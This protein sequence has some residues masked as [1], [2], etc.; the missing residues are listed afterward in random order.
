MIKKIQN[1]KFYKTVL[2]AIILIVSSGN[3]FAEVSYKEQAELI[4][5]QVNEKVKNYLQTAKQ[6]DD[7]QESNP[8]LEDK[9]VKKLSKVSE[10]IL[11][12]PELN[13]KL[14][15]IFPKIDLGEINAKPPQINQ[16]MIFVSSSIP[17]NS[18]RQFAIQSNK[19]NGVLVL[20]GLINDSFKQ[21]ASFIKSLNDNGTRAIIDPISFKLFD[22]RQV[23]EI[24]V[25][26]DDS[27]CMAGKCE[28]TPLFDKISGNISLDYALEQI[29]KNGQFTKKE[30]QRFLDVLRGGQGAK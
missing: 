23:P 24:V 14:N 20:R 13:Q 7:R 6:L 22:V 26:V 3:C 12:D 21:T 1:S 30:A 19:A 2:L 16:L 18:L 27:G 17:I 15:Q 9:Q 29:A 10:Q 5:N 4:N 11:N 25:I 28:H 8:F